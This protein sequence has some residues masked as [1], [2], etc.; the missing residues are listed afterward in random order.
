MGAHLCFFKNYYRYGRCSFTLFFCQLLWLGFG[1]RVWVGINI[2]VIAWVTIKY[3]M[4]RVVVRGRIAILYLR[5]GAN[6]LSLFQM[7][8]F[9]GLL[10]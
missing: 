4:L 7:M 2:K 10:A 5:A 1:I 6:K 9:Y 3:V 8:G